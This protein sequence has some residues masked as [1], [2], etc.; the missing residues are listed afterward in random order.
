MAYFYSLA[1][2]RRIDLPGTACAFQSNGCTGSLLAHGGFDAHH[3]WPKSMGGP[4]NQSDELALCPNHHRR[5]HSLVRYLVEL[6]DTPADWIVLQHFTSGER[7][8]AA[9]AVSAWVAAGRP[10]ISGWSSP[11]ARV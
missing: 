9:Y 11:A 4:E 8:T 10:A 6:N 1:E 3:R 7:E 2:P 5:Q